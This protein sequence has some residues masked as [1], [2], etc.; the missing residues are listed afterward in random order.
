M[1]SIRYSFLLV[2]GITLG[3]GVATCQTLGALVTFKGADPGTCSAPSLAT[4]F[5]QSDGS[6]KFYVLLSGLHPGDVPKLV[7]TNPVG[8]SPWYTVSAPVVK[9]P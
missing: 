7:W 4:T 5:T 1:R 8:A 6:V 2:A 9:S 3:A